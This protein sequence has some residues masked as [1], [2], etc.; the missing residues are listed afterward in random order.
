M[1]R[2][3]IKAIVRDF[4]ENAVKLLLEVP[5]N[6]RELLTI[7]ELPMLDNIDFNHMI[8]VRTSFV[9][10]DYR[11]VEADVVL[12]APLRRRPGDQQRRSITIYILIEHQSEPDA[13]MPFRVLEYVVQIYKAQAREWRRRHSSFA[14]FRFQPV[15]PVVFY[16]G[17][18][19][20]ENLG[21]LVDLVDMGEDFEAV[22]PALAP[23]FLNLSAVPAK[24][25]ETIGGF[26]WV[27]RLIQ[28]RQAR[29]AEFRELL[30]RAVEHLETMAAPERLRWLELLSYIHALVYH[31]RNRTERADLREQI[32]ASVRTDSHRREVSAMGKTIAEDL[33]QK[34]RKQGS[35][36]EAVRSRRKILLEL[37]RERFRDLP[38]ETAA[39]IESTTNLEK[40]D[41]WLRRF[42]T[43]G[44]LEEVGIGD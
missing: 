43:A 23:L 11:H 17:T 38:R 29:R 31:E 10:R 32:E 33:M 22:I 36:K 21:R 13:M 7:P 15:L 35:K 25:L 27:L 19:R 14:G 6:V 3:R 16:T 2:A 37:L 1:S 41:S 4:S 40:L 24:K 26:G 34:G 9:L 42:A 8:R 18:R 28:E 30:R 39:T 12:R 5:A 20:W 44:S